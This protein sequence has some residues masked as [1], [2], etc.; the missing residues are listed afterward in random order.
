MAVLGKGGD[1]IEAGDAHRNLCPHSRTVPL[2]VCRHADQL[3][4]K[5]FY[6]QTGGGLVGIEAA[7]KPK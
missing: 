5:K 7:E 6:S 2:I 3:R 1:G 4:S